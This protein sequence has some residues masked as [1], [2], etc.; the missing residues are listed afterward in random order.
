M[1]HGLDGILENETKAYGPVGKTWILG[2][3]MMTLLALALRLPAV[4]FHSFWFD[5][6]Y[7]AQIT[8]S[9][10]IDL[11]QGKALDPGNP[12][13]YWFTAKAWTSQFGR[14]EIG[15]RS[16]SILCGVLTVPVIGLLGRYL[17][18]PMT[19]LV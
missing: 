5:E 8:E 6:A 15:F 14:S 1:D 2:V 18:G 11:A 3:A 19:G 10:Y 9:S 13:L 4:D 12:P 16:F 17:L 7:T